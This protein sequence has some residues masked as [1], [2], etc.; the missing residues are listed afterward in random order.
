MKTF[1]AIAVAAAAAL[2]L[3]A[4]ATG[5]GPGGP[6]A[7]GYVDGYDDD[8]YGPWYDGYWGP[9]DA[10]YYRT[11]PNAAYLRDAGH[12]FQHAAGPHFHG[13]HARAGHAPARG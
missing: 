8:F 2:S 10:F 3:G 7:Y 1:A 4:C 6:Y 11:G 13:F 9:D 12:H 5:P